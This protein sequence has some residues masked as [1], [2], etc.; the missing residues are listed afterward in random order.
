[1]SDDVDLEL[2]NAVF[3]QAVPYNHALGLVVVSATRSPAV[4]TTRLPWKAELVGNPETG[5]LHG[6]ALTATMDTSCGAAVFLKLEVPVP[7][8]TL[9]L[10]VDLLKPGT[11][12]RDVLVRAECFRTTR[13][14]GFAKAIAFHDDP[15]DPIATAAATFMLSTKGQLLKGAS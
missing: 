8:A 7:L 4:V 11:P 6:G 14:V 13:Q 10:R 9:D 1:M 5:V 3:S 2:L 12:H 15:N